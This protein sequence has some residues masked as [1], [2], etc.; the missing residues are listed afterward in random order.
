MKEPL[1]YPQ[2]IYSKNLTM[3]EVRHAYEEEFGQSPPLV[4]KTPSGWVAGN[5]NPWDIEGLKSES[6]E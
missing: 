2:K 1:E 4:Y 6:E 5:V 3:S